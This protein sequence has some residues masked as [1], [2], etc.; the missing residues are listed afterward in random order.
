[1]TS[2]RPAPSPQSPAPS[3][4]AAPPV[5]SPQSPAPTPHPPR[6]SPHR[7]LPLRA[8]LPAG[9]LFLAAGLWYLRP[10]LGPWPLL[11]VGLAWL[12]RLAQ[13][14]SLFPR[15]AFDGPLALF[16]LSAAVGAAISI[17][18]AAAWSSAFF[19]TLGAVV[20]YYAVLL[21]PERVRLASRRIE[22]LRLLLLLLP[23]V[24]AA[25]F[26][27]T[28]DWQAWQEKLGWLGPALGLLASLRQPAPGH[29][30]HP[31]M[32]GGL[33]A[34]LL[35]LQIGALRWRR[36][37]R[38]LR[39]AGLALIALSLLGL[40]AS[41]SRGA[42][43]ALL[44]A[45]GLWLAWR[46]SR[47]LLQA[48]GRPA[49][50]RRRELAQ[51]AMM[52]A[53]GLLA[54]LA[55]LATPTGERLLAA[56]NQ[57][58]LTLWKDALQLL[59]DTPLTG[60]GFEAFQMAYVSYGLLLHVGYQ[61]H[62]HN[63]LLEIW[64]RQGALGL[65]A[66]AWMVAVVLRLRHSPS[67]W[68]PWA[69]ASLA[70]IALHGLVDIPL[71]G[72]RGLM[73]A[74]IPLA[75]LAR[76]P[77]GQPVILPRR[78]GLALAAALALLLADA[79]LAFTPAGRAVVQTNLGALAQTRAE[80]AL[81]RWPE[82]PLQDELRRTGAVDL[83][84]IVARYQAA[85]AENPANAAANRRLGQIELSLGHYA[86]ARQ[87]LEA[88]YA[89]A[90]GQRATRQLLAESYAIE[91]EL[92]QAAALLRTVDTSLNQIDARIWWYNHIGE[93]QRAELLRTVI[94]EW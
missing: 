60:L 10:T 80:L 41:G 32:A 30:L 89:A 47:G 85:L 84:P 26:L 83:T 61:P 42:W 56:G 13:T 63:L 91:G 45:A 67:R 50:G 25:Y 15:S 38:W 54:G 73:L 75:L 79:L 28:T 57:S 69:L 4:R 94:G 33:L 55:L 3:P 23:S 66:V 20:V 24:A 2:A 86:A 53:A 1:M 8:A 19:V 27:L 6:P 51:M 17:D 43:L 46:A 87:H 68:R 82:W 34:A 92:E 18:R 58:R 29:L 93:P 77:L 74:P 76:G 5:P 31:N 22:P 62:S 59:G 9:L 90:P 44:A 81:Y 39:V 16:L 14:G 40:L 78:A 49:A 70:V 35:P 21:T 11:L 12:L 48:A 65:L 64:L 37:P 7:S 88:A 36:S 72:G 52:L 71:Y